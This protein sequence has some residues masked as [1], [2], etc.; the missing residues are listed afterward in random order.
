MLQNFGWG[1]SPAS[2]MDEI[3]IE[4][5]QYQILTLDDQILL[6]VIKVESELAH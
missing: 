6:R 4:A 3:T 2:S 5:Y 1:F